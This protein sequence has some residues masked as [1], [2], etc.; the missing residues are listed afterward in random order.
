MIVEQWNNDVGTVE[1]RWRN[2]GTE[3]VE[4]CNRDDGR[5]EQWEQ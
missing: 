5:V 4:Q 3:M 1:Q 2:S